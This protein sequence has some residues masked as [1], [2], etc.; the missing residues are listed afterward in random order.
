VY[1]AFDQ[2]SPNDVFDVEEVKNDRGYWEFVTVTKATSIQTGNDKEDASATSAGAS[3]GKSGGVAAPRS[4]F[5]T[6]DERAERQR[7]IV[8]QSQSSME[9]R[10]PPLTI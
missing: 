2:A 1:K 5:E 9:T 4:N 8:R 3:V 7:Y 10:K 6:P